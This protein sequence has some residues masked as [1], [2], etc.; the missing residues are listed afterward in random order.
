M[1]SRSNHERAPFRP[2]YLPR[3]HGDVR[4]LRFEAGGSPWRSKV[5]P[6]RV[7]VTASSMS[8]HQI[9]MEERYLG[10]LKAANRLREVAQTLPVARRK[11]F[12][13]MA[14][15]LERTALVLKQ[16]IEIVGSALPSLAGVVSAKKRRRTVAE[17][18]GALYE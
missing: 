6:V 13:A 10:A 1:P 2:N 5:V 16:Q 4:C 15:E 8:V 12:W 18:L 7:A 11:E 14:R 17:E 3:L 9:I